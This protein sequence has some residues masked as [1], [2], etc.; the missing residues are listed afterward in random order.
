[1]AEEVSTFCS[2]C[3]G[4]S[5][6]PA[7]LLPPLK[8]KL[9]WCVC[10]FVSVVHVWRRGV[11][12][13]YEWVVGAGLVSLR[14]YLR[15]TTDRIHNDWKIPTGHNYSHIGITLLKPAGNLAILSRIVM[16]QRWEHL[17]M[18]CYSN[19]ICSPNIHR[20]VAAAPPGINIWSGG[21]T[22]GG[23]CEFILDCIHSF[24]IT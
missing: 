21:K 16:V 5:L 2:P 19:S 20:G 4:F 10:V 1:M 23:C 7:L 15:I 14:Y 3:S 12:S 6:T 13:E 9:V 24:V 8:L 18:V 22:G 17:N 11:A